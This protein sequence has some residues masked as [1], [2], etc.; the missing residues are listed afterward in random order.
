MTSYDNK[1][2]VSGIR[3]EK[4]FKLIDKSSDKCSLSVNE[5]YSSTNVQTVI[6]FLWK[7]ERIFILPVSCSVHSRLSKVNMIKAVSIQLDKWVTLDNLRDTL[8]ETGE[9]EI[10]IITLQEN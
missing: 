9:N 10:L 4:R 2:T 7:Q 1:A 5:N 8:T 3:V 6:F